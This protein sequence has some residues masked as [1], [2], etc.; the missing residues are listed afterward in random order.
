MKAWQAPCLLIVNLMVKS[1]I[2]NKYARNNI[3]VLD[4][5]TIS[6]LKNNDWRN[7]PSGLLRCVRCGL[8][9]ISTPIIVYFNYQAECLLCRR[10]QTINKS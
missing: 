9:R 4:P 1:K 6:M 5:I 2:L 3:N 10:C 7:T 8:H